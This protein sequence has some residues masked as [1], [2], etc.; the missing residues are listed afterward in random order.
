MEN[1]EYLEHLQGIRGLMEERVKFNAL[2]GLSAVFAGIYA[3][4]GAYSAYRM[5][6]FAPEVIYRQVRE[7]DHTPSLVGWLLAIAGIVLVAAL[8]TALYF[9]HRHAQQSG[10]SLWSRA[11]FRLLTQFS[12]PMMAGGVFVLALVWRGYF[13]LVSS[14][15]LLFYG[16]ALITAANHTLSD[17]RAL[18]ISMLVTAGISLFYPGYG[19]YFWAFGFGILH[20]IYGSIMYIKYER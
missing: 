7:G 6:Y 18:G 5:I 8:A 3:L 15:C 17:I 4:I 12:I 13:S 2:S 14:S 20:I 19:L 9:S 1:K 11:F 16:L 10:K